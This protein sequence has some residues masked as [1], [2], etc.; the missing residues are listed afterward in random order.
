LPLFL[1]SI[2]LSAASTKA[3]VEKPQDRRPAARAALEAAGCTL[4]DYYFALGHADVIVIYEAPD[5]ITAA[6][7]SMTLGASG[8]ASSVETMQLFTMEEA[9][10]AMTKAGQVQK[11]YKPP[12][13]A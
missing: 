11:S 1:A 5:A 10:T 2:K 6:S 12:T 7:V 13:A 3:V 4:K 9:M 8:A